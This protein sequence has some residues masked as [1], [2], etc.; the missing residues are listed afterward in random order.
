MMAQCPKCEGQLSERNTCPACGY[1]GN[2]AP[3]TPQNATDG[4]ASLRQF[5]RDRCE[6]AGGAHQT[7]A[8]AFCKDQGVWTAEECVAYCR[9]RLGMRGRGDFAAPQTRA[10]FGAPSRDW[11]RFVPKSGVEILAHMGQFE[12]VEHI[13]KYQLREPG[14]DD[15]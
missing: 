10:L 3:G 12:T 6:A 8:D 15:E 9:G 11:M 1:N 5:N 14:S 13:K 7:S 2:K 4:R